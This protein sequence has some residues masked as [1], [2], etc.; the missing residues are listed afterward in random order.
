MDPDDHSTPENSESI[1]VFP[2]RALKIYGLD[3]VGVGMIYYLLLMG[4]SM[5]SF[6]ERSLYS[7]LGRT[8]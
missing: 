3:P 1:E 8:P 7:L 6:V 4:E 5:L 2:V